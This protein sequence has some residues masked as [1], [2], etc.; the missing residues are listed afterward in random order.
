MRPPKPKN[1]STKILSAKTKNIGNIALLKPVLDGVGIAKIIDSYA[2]M[3]RE[4]NHLTNGQAIEVLVMNR[5]TSPT[6]L[7]HTERWAERYALEET[8]GISP[9]EVNDDRL[10]R[11]LDS[12]YPEI[13]NIEADVALKIMSKYRIKPELIHFD[14][15]SLY[16]EGA[17]EESEVLK[18]GYSR[19]QKPD[20]KQVNIELDVDAKEGMLLFHTPHDGNMVDPKMAL[21]NLEK[22]KKR[23]NVQKM[24]MVGDRN[25]I[26]SEV[27]IL[28]AT[29]YHLDFI[30]AVKMTEKTKELVRSVSDSEFNP[31]SLE[32]ANEGDYLAVD[33]KI[34][35]FTHGGR[36]LEARAIIVLS[37]KKQESDRKRRKEALEN[38]G[39]EL[40]KIKRKVDRK[41]GIYSKNIEFVKKSIQSV[42]EKRER[43]KRH[44]HLFEI[45][46]KEESDSERKFVSFSYSVK[47]GDEIEQ[48]KLDGKY[49]IATTLPK[50]EWSAD[51]VVNGYRSR[52][53]AESRIR[54][55][56]NE[57]AVR[58]IFLHD[59]KRIVS[60]VF[61]SILAL[62]VYSLL[63]ILARR[64]GIMTVWGKNKNPVTARQLFFAFQTI[65]LV[66]IVMKDGS[67]I[68]TVE[69]L[70]PVQKYVLEKLGFDPPQSYA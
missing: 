17:Y 47:S 54:N 34:V 44:S 2:P 28:L 22:I 61:A 32:G 65:M 18:L 53:I 16:F 70:A 58:P 67:N 15:T 24:I 11:A 57:I 39:S 38:I 5:L 19:D 55:M 43:N 27:A 49:M 31:I 62:M 40:D 20:K 30:G 33:E 37:K 60:L 3:E 26:D 45:R 52:Y 36:E 41:K 35:K 23:L 13:E 66:K 48:R 10:G 7:V 42:F 4:G 46:L 9:D 68:K 64:S 56:K 6:P 14:S 69:D 8:C 29:D 50:E 12:I 25:S 21:L 59:D 51:R 1:I 63:E